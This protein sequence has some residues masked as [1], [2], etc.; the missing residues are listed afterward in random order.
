MI[1]NGIEVPADVREPDDPPHVLYAGRL[2]AEK[3][4]RELVAA[5]RGLPL[6]VAGDGPLRDEVPGALGM[7]RHDRAPAA[8]RA[9]G[10]RRLSVQP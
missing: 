4:V 3:G 7:V 2:S 10:R 6:V 1:P 5:T 8:L 9:S